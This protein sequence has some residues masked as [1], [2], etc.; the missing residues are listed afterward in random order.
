MM[1]KAYMISERGEY[2]DE[3]LACRH[4]CALAIIREG[5]LLNLDTN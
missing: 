1:M 3:V 2:W 5:T 4:M